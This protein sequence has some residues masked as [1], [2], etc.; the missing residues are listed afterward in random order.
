MAQTSSRTTLA[1]IKPSDRFTPNERI[2][3]LVKNINNVLDLLGATLRDLSGESGASPQFAADIDLQGHRII[4]V[5]DPTADQD[6][7]TKAWVLKQL[8]EALDNF[9]V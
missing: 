4:N 6:A 9:R 8:T 1:V 5:A 2:D 3:Q 7:A